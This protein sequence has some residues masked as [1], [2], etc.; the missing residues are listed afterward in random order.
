[1]INL[2]TCGDNHPTV[3]K[4]EK[5]SKDGFESFKDE[6]S[7]HYLKL[8]FQP[9]YGIPLATQRGEQQCHAAKPRPSIPATGRSAALRGRYPFENPPWSTRIFCLQRK[10]AGLDHQGQRKPSRRL[11]TGSLA[12]LP[13][14]DDWRVQ[15]HAAVTLRPFSSLPIA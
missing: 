5:T 1:M 15:L 8:T 10:I 6:I 3:T 11:K 12:D 7:I 4:S 2:R 13:A 9:S 14:F